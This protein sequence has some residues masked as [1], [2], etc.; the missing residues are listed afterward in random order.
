MHKNK[1]ITAGAAALG[2]TLALATA[3]VATA[4]AAGPQ[5]SAAA[6]PK[7]SI[8]I[9][10]RTKTLLK[11]ET[12]QA[13]ASPVTRGGVAAGKCPANSAQGALNVA[14]H[15]NWKGKWYA[16]YNEYYITAILGDTETTKKY[17]WGLYVNG[18][19]SSKG[20][21]DVKLKTGDKL[22]FKVTKG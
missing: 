16:S 15:G 7:V 18:K 8:T 9:Q 2:M 4:S 17:Y 22:V 20:A 12:V 1:A 21:C 19:S 11:T 10:G 14:T 6:A 3:Q 13:P 5:A